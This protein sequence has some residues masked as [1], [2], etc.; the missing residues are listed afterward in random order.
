MSIALA[1]SETEYQRNT[2]DNLLLKEILRQNLHAELKI[3]DAPPYRL[4]TI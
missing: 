4:G 3:W 1:T 2:D